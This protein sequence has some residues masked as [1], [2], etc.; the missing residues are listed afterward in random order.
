MEYPNNL[1]HPE[2]TKYLISRD[3][4]C[5]S[6]YF[7]RWLKPDVNSCGYDRY[8]VNGKKRFAHRLVA[9][10]YIPNYNEL[11][12]IDHIDRDKKNNKVEN[13]RWIN[14]SNNSLNRPACKN[15]KLGIKNI[16]YMTR[17]NVYIFNKCVVG[18]TICKRFKTLEEAVDFKVD[19]H[20]K[21]N[22]ILL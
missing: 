17:D 21:N 11:K 22:I 9:Q 15:N 19:W 4:Q 5:Y 10:T 6:T 14:H 8:H 7:K 1:P 16:S 13:L 12:C 2:Y 18:K 3:G 20:F